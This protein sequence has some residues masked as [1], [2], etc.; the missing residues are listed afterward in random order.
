ML[1]V[2]LGCPECSDHGVSWHEMTSF[3]HQVYYYHGCIEAMCV[4]K[5]RDKIDA[6]DI[7]SFFGNRKGVEFT[8]WFSSLGFHPKTHVAR[9]A[10]L[11]NVS[12]HVGPPVAS[13]NKF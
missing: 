12:Q 5:F 6:H 4:R 9:L 11:S 2:E 7:P 10:V 1:E 13:R 8:K 3:A